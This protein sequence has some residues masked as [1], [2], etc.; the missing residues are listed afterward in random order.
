[1]NTR[2]VK[3]DFRKLCE[4]TPFEK[5]QKRQERILLNGFYEVERLITTRKN[6]TV[7][8]SQ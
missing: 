1:M 4:N 7:S 6:G 3:I 5:E 8:Y 2:K